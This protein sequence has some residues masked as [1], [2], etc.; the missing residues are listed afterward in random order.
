MHYSFGDKDDKEYGHISFPIYSFA[1]SFLETKPGELPPPI[2][3]DFPESQK[4]K[5]MRTRS[6]DDFDW[7][8]GHTYSISFHSMYLDFP[9][10]QLINL[11]MMPNMSLCTF[12]GEAGLRVALYEK[13]GSSNKHLKELNKYIAG[14]Q[15]SH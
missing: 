7:K 13:D 1:H 6:R 9:N 2:E 12:W 15:V 4:S 10:W 8:I 5:E 14:L 11:P 3:Q